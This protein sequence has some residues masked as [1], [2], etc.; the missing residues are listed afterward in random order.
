M[1]IYGL[2]GQFR[3][4]IAAAQSPSRWSRGQYAQLPNV[5]ALQIVFT[6]IL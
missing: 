2:V 4:N 5:H 3:S 6:F 1:M